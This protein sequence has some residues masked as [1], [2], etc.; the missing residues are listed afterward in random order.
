MRV[1]LSAPDSGADEI[2]LRPISI[3][4]LDW[5][6][7]HLILIGFCWSRAGAVLLLNILL[8]ILLD[9]TLECSIGGDIILE[10][11]IGGWRKVFEERGVKVQQLHLAVR[12]SF[13]GK[14]VDE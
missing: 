9:I 10:C 4:S 6:S 5:N 3:I 11:S 14:A 8:N 1:V 13:D 2:K 12:L 7:F